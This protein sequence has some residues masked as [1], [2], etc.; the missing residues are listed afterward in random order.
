MYS[1]SYFRETAVPAVTVLLKSEEENCSCSQICC[2]QTH[3]NL[4]V[5]TDESNT[6]CETKPNELT[7]F[8]NIVIP[9]MVSPP[10][11]QLEEK[12][13]AGWIK[14]SAPHDK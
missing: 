10:H 3:T 14:H 7:E 2:C 5:S 1:N 6:S 8:M 13:E 12:S 9:E 4:Q 11:Y